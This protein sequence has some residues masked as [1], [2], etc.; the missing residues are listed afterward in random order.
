MEVPLPQTCDVKEALIVKLQE[1]DTKIYMLLKSNKA[2]EEDL[3]DEDPDWSSYIE[4]NDRIIIR[5]K[6]EI[7]RILNA[8]LTAGVDIDKE[9]VLTK[10]T[11][12]AL[13]MPEDVV[14]AKK[15]QEPSNG[16]GMEVPSLE[17]LQQ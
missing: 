3:K 1:L 12:R 13:Y 10:M 17:V 4:E 9:N 15:D 16:N 14:P 2:I 7:L 5:T 11:H 8:F 6:D